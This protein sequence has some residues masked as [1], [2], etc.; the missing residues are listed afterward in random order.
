MCIYILE[1]RWQF[2]PTKITDWKNLNRSSHWKKNHFDHTLS[3]WLNIHESINS[4][5]I[6]KFVDLFM[7]LDGMKNG[8][9]IQI[10]SKIGS[11]IQR[12]YD[13]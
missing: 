8:E 3:T 9:F 11:C 12:D 5:M 10:H 2:P 1:C 7:C 13:I 6:D 4:K